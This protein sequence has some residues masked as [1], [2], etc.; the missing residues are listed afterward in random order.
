VIK[1]GAGEGKGI[2]GYRLEEKGFPN[3]IGK[4]HA[5][6][7]NVNVIVKAYTYIRSLGAMGL[8]EASVKAVENANYLM[9]K[10][11]AYYYLPY[12]RPCQHEFVLSAKWQKEKYGIKALDIAKRLID[13]GIHPPTVYFPLIVE[14]AMMIEPTESESKETLDQFVDIMI[15]IAKECEDNPEIVKS[16][17]HNTPVRRLDEAKAARDPDINFFKA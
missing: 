10:L 12:D 9:N 14:E 17:P 5:F 7:G 11:K 8:K 3:S 2:G 13:Y 6:N 1:E 4:V 15:K 16:A